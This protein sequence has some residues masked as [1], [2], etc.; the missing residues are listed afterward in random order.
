MIKIAHRGASGYEFENSIS[1]F[2]KAVA[3][4]IRYVE[5]DVRLTSD[6]QLIVFHDHRLDRCT[7]SNGYVRDFTFDEIRNKVLLSNG[8]KIPS[9]I[10]VCN[11]LCKHEVNVLIELKNDNIGALVYKDTISVMKPSQFIIGSFFHQQILEIKQQNQELQT[12][13]MFESY[14][15]NLAQYIRETRVDFVAFGFE[16]SSSSLVKEIKSVK[17]KA[18]VWTIDDSEDIK[19]AKDL[20]VD[21]IISNYPDRI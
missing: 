15:I 20:N 21:G 9:L 5:L 18:L 19:K 4:G 7:N 13:I 16:S 14:P 3:L 8:E 6:N 2:K 17:A 11:L 10:E 1:A 12:C